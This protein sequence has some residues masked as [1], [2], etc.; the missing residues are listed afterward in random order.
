MKKLT[1]ILFAVLLML[2]SCIKDNLDACA[3]LLH[4]YFSYI[5]GQTN[6]FY[7]T[8]KTDVY[9]N[10]YYKESGTKYRETVI[11]RAS[12]DIDRPYIR[13]KQREDK[14]SITLV[15]WTHDD[16][17]EYVDATTT[18]MGIGYVHLKE[19]TPG[20]GICN[21]VEDLLYG[22]ATF[23]AGDHVERRDVTIPF[24]R[25]VCRVRIT[26]IP[27]TV[28]NGNADIETGRRGGTTYA[29]VIVPH[30]DDYTFH[31]L[32]TRN[33]I[34]Y[35]NVTS[36]EAI[37]LQPKAYY[38]EKDGNV[39]TPWFGAFSS[40]EE[41][42]KV[43]VYIKEAPVA[44]F[45]CAPIELASTP[46]DYIDLVIDGHYI[47]PQMSIMVNGWKLATVESIM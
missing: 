36:G 20:S 3:G 41:Y 16:R 46:G 32:G 39:K 28:Q 15:A 21:P 1:P 17:V 38:D 34:D 24:V 40:L 33:K 19:I 5:Y 12:I 6:Q 10:Y 26:M 8:A 9:L 14:D 25:A 11:D 47:R 29:P 45:D 22:Q 7:S 44:T 4:I 42:L 31:L 30:A 13:E 23:H 2:S 43:N 37:T 18:P 35:N 27:Q